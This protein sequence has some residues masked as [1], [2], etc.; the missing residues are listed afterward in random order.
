LIWIKLS[1]G[2]DTTAQFVSMHCPAPMDRSDRLGP[3]DA[4]MTVAV[5]HCGRKSR[6]RA[7]AGD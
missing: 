4:A 6:S 1:E 7:S 5:E 3:A 2:Y